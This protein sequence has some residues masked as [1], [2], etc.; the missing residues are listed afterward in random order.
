MMT[1]CPSCSKQLNVP[2]TAVGKKVRCPGCQ[3]VFEVGAGGKGPAQHVQAT[4]P[5][6]RPVPARPAPV[7][8]PEPE[9]DDFADMPVRSNGG[10]AR[11]IASSGAMW[12]RIGGIFTIVVVVLNIISQFIQPAAPQMGGNDGA[13]AA[14]K[15]LGIACVFVL[16]VL[17]A[18]FMLIGAGNLSNLKGRGMVVTGAVFA[19]ILS[20]VYLGFFAL[21]LLAIIG[22]MSLGIPMGGVMLI[23]FGLAFMYLAG[24]I[25][26]LLGG[27][28]ALTTL[29]RPEVKA[30]YGG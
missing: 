7:S 16:L 9:E 10:G 23:L 13:Q 28:K 21:L 19:F 6:P 11:R 29:G 22:L 18:I 15:L 26:A 14:G 5:A 27:I 25:L 12:L 2:E 24:M 20:V 3:Q 4:P 17:P 8:R 30:A 1:A